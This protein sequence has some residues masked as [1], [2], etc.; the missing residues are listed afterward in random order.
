MLTISRAV[1]V[2]YADAY[3]LLVFTFN[4]FGNKTQ[5]SKGD[6]QYLICPVVYKRKGNYREIGQMERLYL[7]VALHQTR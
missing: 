7:C 1:R 6:L 2:I 3:A 5:V 4:S